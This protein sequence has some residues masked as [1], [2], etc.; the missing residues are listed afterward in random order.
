MVEPPKI[1]PRKADIVKKIISLGLLAVPIPLAS[2]AMYYILK[3]VNFA[4]LTRCASQHKFSKKLCYAQ[5][6]WLSAA[7]VVKTLEHQY[8]KCNE[9]RV[10]K[11]KCKSK[12]LKL[13]EDWKQ[14]E[15]KAKIKFDSELRIEYRKLQTKQHDEARDNG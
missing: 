6:D 13:L 1:D 5:C 4:C 11:F 2:A 12:A 10:N 8:S 9:L 7:E 3:Q 15:V 14:R